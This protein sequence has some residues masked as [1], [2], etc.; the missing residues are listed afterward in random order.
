[1][2]EGEDAGDEASGTSNSE[3]VLDR[4]IM[5]SLNNQDFAQASAPQSEV[6]FDCTSVSFFDLF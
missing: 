5:R 3:A 6:S 2:Q 1:M 4:L